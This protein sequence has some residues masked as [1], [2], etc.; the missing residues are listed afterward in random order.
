MVL[1]IIGWVFFDLGTL[2]SAWKYIGV[3]FGLGDNLFINN[4]DKYLIGTNFILLFI[5]ILFCTKFVR[6]INR[7]MNN[8]L[9]KKYLIF[10]IVIQSLILISSVAF[11]VSESYNPFLYF[12]F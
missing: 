6:N 8:K 4:L 12:R 11:L 3:M 9:N 7:K 2:S 1:V 10:S 5:S